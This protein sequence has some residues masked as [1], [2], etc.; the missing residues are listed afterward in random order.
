MKSRICVLF[1]FCVAV[2]ISVFTNTEVRA[3]SVELVPLSF[4]GMQTVD[5]ESK[6]IGIAHL[7]KGEQQIH[8]LILRWSEPVE[9][10]GSLVV[11]VADS[12]GF[13]HALALEG[14]EFL[15]VDESDRQLL[16]LGVEVTR[17]GTGK[18]YV[19]PDLRS[20]ED[21]IMTLYVRSIAQDAGS[22]G[23][24]VV[25]LVP[26]VNASATAVGSSPL[27]AERRGRR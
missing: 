17:H 9:D 7:P 26:S 12:I 13:E 14:E 10:A 3:S 19:F 20:G 18:L 21:D 22:R 4:V 23:H 11:F 25:V 5:L 1:A 27:A 15:S 6:P 24:L 16:E 2:W 8:R